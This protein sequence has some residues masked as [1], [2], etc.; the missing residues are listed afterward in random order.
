MKRILTDHVL[1]EEQDLVIEVCDEPGPGGA[2]HLYLVRGVD[3]N[4]MARINFQ[5]G[6]IQEVGVNGLTNEVLLAIVIDRL[7]GFDQGPFST[8]D[9]ALA[10]H[11]CLQAIGHLRARTIKRRSRGVEGRSVA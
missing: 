2:N 3:G 10:L 6:G 4:I 8:I 11:G 1:D 5:E 9:N 7:R